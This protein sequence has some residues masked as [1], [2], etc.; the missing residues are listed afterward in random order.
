VYSLLLAGV[1][2][3]DR[4]SVVHISTRD[5]TGGAAIAAYRLHLGLLR[6]DVDSKMVVQRK[7]SDDDRVIEAPRD[8]RL[9]SRV[10]RKVRDLQLRPAAHIRRFE[11]FS[12]DRARDP[13]CMPRVLPA[14]DVYHLHWAS[15]FVDHPT[16][17]AW[18][19]SRRP[20]VWTMHDMYPF[21]GGCHYN[22]GCDR[23]LTACG[24]CPA[25]GSAKPFDRSTQ[26]FRRKKAAYARLD[27]KRVKF[28]AASAWM[29][30]AAATSTLLKRFDIVH[31][32]YG[33]DADVFRPRDRASAREIFGIPPD[34]KVVMFAAQ[35]V[36]NHR[37]GADLLLSALAQLDVGEPVWLLSVG[38]GKLPAGSLPNLVST[39]TIA[40]DVLLS[41]AYSAAD[42]FVTP[43]RQEAFGQVVFEAMACGTPAVGFAVGGIPDMVRPG[44]TG[45]LASP[46]HV[47]ELRDAIAALL[48]DRALA[49][50]MSGACR[51][52]VLDEYRLETQAQRYK[53]LYD[54]LLDAADADARIATAQ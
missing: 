49:E 31:I 13:M 30:R 16:F 27:A 3:A 22:A 6:L 18:V 12:D 23:Y 34:A 37:K 33:L 29:A 42:A 32:P 41:F 24:S 14:S 36:K 8:G 46:E 2:L 48:S 25:I 45:L 50:R 39:G 47:G 20:L 19:G 43:A 5:T 35:S 28:V 1:C 17:L 4:P 38:A 51:R 54:E 11:L 52:V 9:L 7:G 40:N 53:M 10:R 26:I 21:M 44:V 15:A